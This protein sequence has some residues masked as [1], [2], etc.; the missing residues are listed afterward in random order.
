MS[1]LSQS[2]VPTS[3]P[4]SGL[5][6]LLSKLLSPQSWSGVEGSHT[7]QQDRAIVVFPLVIREADTPH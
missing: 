2:L 1:V 7:P 4:A 6:K 3:D 5:W